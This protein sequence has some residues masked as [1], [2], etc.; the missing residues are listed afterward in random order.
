MRSCPS[1]VRHSSGGRLRVDVPDLADVE[2]AGRDRLGEGHR[3]AK[4]RER[5]RP[6]S[7]VDDE[8]ACGGLAAAVLGPVLEMVVPERRRPDEPA[9]PMRGHAFR[10]RDDVGPDVGRLGHADLEA[11][12]RAGP[13]E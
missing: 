1:S 6:V 3:G 7:V 10:H 13:A 9:G 5:P 8:R 4:D 12:D 11:L 2:V